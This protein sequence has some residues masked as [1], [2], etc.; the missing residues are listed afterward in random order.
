VSGALGAAPGAA[1][2]GAAPATIDGAPVPTIALA[3]VEAPEAASAPA[4][5]N[6]NTD[7]EL[8]D[9]AGLGVAPMGPALGAQIDAT[10]GEAV[11]LAE[12]TA[13]LG[14]IM[15]MRDRSIAL[16]LVDT[17][18]PAPL[19]GMEEDAPADHGTEVAA[20][21][22]T[23]P[24]TPDAGQPA[25]QQQTEQAAQPDEIDLAALPSGELACVVPPSITLDVKAA[26]E[27]LLMINSP[28]HA[29]SVAELAYSDL[30]F[31]VKIDRSG[32]GEIEVLGFETSVEASLGFEDGEALDFTVPFTGVDR[33]ERVAL[34][35]S[36]PVALEIHAFE[37]GAE[38][39]SPG[40]VFPGQPK[41]F[42]DVRRRGG[43]YLTEFLPVEGV[44]DFVQ[45]YSHWVRRGG[46]AGVVKM[47]LDFA[48]RHRD[49]LA[50]T[51]GEGEFAQPTFTV[52]RSSRGR[53]EGQTTT[54]LGAM[55]C[56][57]IDKVE[58][59]LIGAALRDIIISQR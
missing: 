54:R 18:E 12:P 14:D 27:T 49:R 40:H 17:A 37:F 55:A 10:G 11:A 25:Q 5:A 8:S 46:D 24:V 47:Y 29:D 31:G 30:S 33:V 6:V 57:E 41:S 23:S 35:W 53:F 16:A 7:L 59:H 20:I 36:D 50:G 9:A 48:S 51:C 22:P 26:G 19:Q 45:V 2:P 13:G 28:C 44:G 42:R 21:D 52:T 32:R 1:S 3:R 15:T 4:R 43:G 39:G 34:S 38:A 58:D 56:D